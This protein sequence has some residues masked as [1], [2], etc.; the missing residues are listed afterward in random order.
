[1]NPQRRS[2]AIGLSKSR[3]RRSHH[4]QSGNLSARSMARKRG[5]LRKG[6]SSASV[7]RKINPP[8]SSQTDAEGKPVPTLVPNPPSLTVT[9]RNLP[10]PIPCC[11]VLIGNGG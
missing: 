8:K 1:M 9:H 11:K 6:S 5:S 10:S 2:V 4:C 7:R 3:A